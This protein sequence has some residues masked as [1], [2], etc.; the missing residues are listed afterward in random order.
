MT[1]FDE[2]RDWFIRG[3]LAIVLG[4]VIA[5]ISMGIGLT[6]GYNMAQPDRIKNDSEM[7]I[8]KVRKV[9]DSS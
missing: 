2:K 7:K 4:A 5:L 6:V 3:A 1:V 8:D 9:L